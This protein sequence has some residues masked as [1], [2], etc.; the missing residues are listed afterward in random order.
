MKK[1]GCQHEDNIYLKESKIVQLD[2]RVF[3]PVRARWH[4][5]T[6]TLPCNC[7]RYI[8]GNKPTERLLAYTDCESIR[9]EDIFRKLADVVSTSGI[10]LQLCQAQTYDGAGNMAGRTK[11]CQARFL[12][13]YRLAKYYHC[14]SHE[15][16]LALSHSCQQKE[17]HILME[18]PKK[19]GLFFQFSPKRERELEASVKDL[20]SDSGYS[21]QNLMRNTLG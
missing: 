18:N 6:P 13:A 20:N 17:I 15:L 21:I 4:S 11:G 1:T 7:S 5:L 19:V 12:E 3:W 10:D 16:N 2:F 8:K 14:A 9:G